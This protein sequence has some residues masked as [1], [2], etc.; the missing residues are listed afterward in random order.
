MNWLLRP[1]CWILGHKYQILS[2]S[3]FYIRPPHNPWTEHDK[4]VGC[5]RCHKCELVNMNERDKGPQA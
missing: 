4:W 2:L 3:G 5:T 1:I